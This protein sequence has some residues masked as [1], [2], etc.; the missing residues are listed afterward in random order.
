MKTKKL[1][2]IIGISLFCLLFNPAFADGPP[3]PPSGH[4]NSGNATPPSGG[5]GA[6]IDGGLSILLA[7]AA[8]FGAKKVYD[9]RKKEKTTT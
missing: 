7:L 1:V 5:G 6:P 9:I 8:A 2:S 3:P 4:G